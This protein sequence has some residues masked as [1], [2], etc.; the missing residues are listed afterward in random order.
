MVERG[1]FLAIVNGFRAVLDFLQAG[2]DYLSGII[3][4]GIK[5]LSSIPRFF[6]S[7]RSI[8]NTFPTPF[9]SIASFCL[10]VRTFVM[11]AHVKAGEQ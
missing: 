6:G 3:A 7:A 10:I 8:I 1:D 5:I 2:Y 9:I 11:I 4:D